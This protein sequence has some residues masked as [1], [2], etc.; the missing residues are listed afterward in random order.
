[1]LRAGAFSGNKSLRSVD[2]EGF[3]SYRGDVPARDFPAYFWKLKNQVFSF[4]ADL[5]N[6]LN[7]P[8]L[9]TPSYTMTDLNFNDTA[10]TIKGG[11]EIKL[12]LKYSF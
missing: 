8:N 1:V 3:S 4:R 10:I 11:R 6:A 2:S 5:F 12:W 9:F 7:H